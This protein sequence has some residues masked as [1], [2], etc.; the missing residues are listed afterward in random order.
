[1]SHILVADDTDS[2]RQLL[3]FFLQDGGHDVVAAVDGPQAL[4][5]AHQQNVDL[6]I[7]DL[8]MPGMAGGEVIREFRRDFPDTPVIALSGG[9]IAFSGVAGADRLLAKPF[10]S[11][12]L[13]G[14]VDDLLGVVPASEPAGKKN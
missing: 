4:E 2:V 5:L 12:A 8:L 13:L 3:T 10:A 7:C 1:M 6:F 11:A 14:L 9:D